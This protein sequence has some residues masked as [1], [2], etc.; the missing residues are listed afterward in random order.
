MNIVTRLI[1]IIAASTGF[2]AAA[3]AADF[4]RGPIAAP[5][6]Y[7]Y[8]W[9]LE[10]VAGIPLKQEY[11][12][13]IGT[14]GGTY[15][16]DTGFYG[17]IALGRQFTPNWRGEI[18]FAWARAKDG[19]ITFNGGGT[20]PQTGKTDVYSFGANLFYGWVWTQFVRPFV[21]AGVGFAHFDVQRIGFPGSAVVIDDTD[22]TI[23]GLLHAGLDFPLTQNFILT[24]RYTAAF[25]P[26]VSF[27]SVP[28]GITR[29]REAT[30]DHLFS[31]GARWFFQ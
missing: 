12:V 18:Y 1:S 13:N 3:S 4:P 11:D 9:Y 29:T 22:T 27:S 5:V 7:T 31:F 26:E 6:A 16:P 28:A 19:A 25:T 20:F 8:S 21:G 14:S 23:V 17:S 15:E 30:I 2:S 10:G 24:S